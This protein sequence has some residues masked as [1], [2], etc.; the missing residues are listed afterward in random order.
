MSNTSTVTPYDNMDSRNSVNGLGTVVG[1]AA[2]VCIG[3]AAAGVVTMARWLAHET[4]ADREAVARVNEVRRRE[5]L[6]TE[7]KQEISGARVDLSAVTTLHLHL[8]DSDSLLRTATAL[9]YRATPAQSGFGQADGAIIL[10][11]KPSGGRLAITQTANGRLAIHT[12]GDQRRIRALVRRHTEERA[13]T[14]LR[15]KGM[16]VKHVRLANGDLQI[17]ARESNT[18][19]SRGPAEVKAQVRADGTAYVDIDKCRGNRCEALVSD[20]ARAVGGLVSGTTKKDAYF[21]LPGEPTK[22]RVKV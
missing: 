15:S 10:L 2:G 19:Q 9:G 17:L 7:N 21:Q 22:T 3:V 5:R 18:G 20:L 11:Q 12:A 4:E 14:H 8:K 1:I 16:E 6:G 13:L